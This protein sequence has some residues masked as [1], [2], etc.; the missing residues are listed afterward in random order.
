MAIAV[1][2]MKEC[3][4][5]LMK[6]NLEASDCALLETVLQIASL[7]RSRNVWVD[8]ESLASLSTEMLRRILFLS[9]KAESLGVNLLFYQMTLP[10][11]KAMRESRLDSVLHIVPSI[12]EASLYCKNRRQT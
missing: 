8:C 3:S 1:Q 12:T 11:K 6:G 5:V 9:G 4:L 10:V 7:S 2:Q